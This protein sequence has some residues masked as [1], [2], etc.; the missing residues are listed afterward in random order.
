MTVLVSLNEIYSQ[1]INFTRKPLQVGDS[2]KQF[3]YGEFGD[4]YGY[5]NK[6]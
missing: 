4:I 1:I 3:S 2:Y 5:R 6:S